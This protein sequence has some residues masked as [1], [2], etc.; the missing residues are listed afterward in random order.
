MSDSAVTSSCNLYDPCVCSLCPGNTHLEP[1]LV[2]RPKVVG[3][4][5]SIE[6]SAFTAA[7][8]EQ[9]VH[10]MCPVGAVGSYMLRTQNIRRHVLVSWIECRN[11]KS[12]TKHAHWVLEAMAL[13]Y[14][15]RCLQPLVGTRG[16]AVFKRE[17]VQA[18]FSAVSWYVPLNFVWFY[19][20]LGSY[21][22]R[23]L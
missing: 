5:S 6:L 23:I 20:E 11:G 1:N 16:M 15:N 4:C 13:V 3:S 21:Y 9:W 19:M 22:S 17:H 18:I 10:M 7:L 14:M 8:R 2:F 12:V